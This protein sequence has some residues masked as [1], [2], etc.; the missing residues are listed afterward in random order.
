MGK[1]MRKQGNFGE[2]LA[3]K[4]L[5][6]KNYRLLKR[7][8]FIHGGELDLICMKDGIITFVEVKLRTTSNFGNGGDAVTRTK[9]Q[10]LLRS[11][12]TYLQ[13]IGHPQKWQLDLIDI[14]YDKKTHKAFIH[15]LPHILEA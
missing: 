15:H 5:E 12:F 7:N 10:K 4:Y 3:L 11:I 6:A 8:Y 9:K 2:D 1:N 13:R 14:L